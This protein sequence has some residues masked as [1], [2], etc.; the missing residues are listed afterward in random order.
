MVRRRRN[1]L[2]PGLCMAQA[3]NQL[4]YLVPR[5]L[6]PFTR[7]C[8]LGNLDL[9]FFS[10]NQILCG[11]AEARAGHLLYLVVQDR[12]RSVQGPVDHRVFATLAGI[13]A[14]AQHVHGFS[15]GLMRF[16]RERTERHG[17]RN[18]IAHDRSGALDLLNGK[19][20]SGGSDLHQIAKA[21]RLGLHHLPGKYRKRHEREC[22]SLLGGTHN[23]LQCS[24]GLR[25][26]GMRFGFVSLAESDKTVVGRSRT[27][28]D[29]VAKS[30]PFRG[31]SE[32]DSLA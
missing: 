5:Q 21:G 15:D 32:P 29:L 27:G 30:V 16:W 13:R 20:G 28:I 17:T 18:E 22:R 10:V 25:P 6:A 1:Q 12:R 8:A 14:R 2:H 23:R 31:N 11:N 4:G 7:F 3:R 9:Q 19:L 26:P 24:H